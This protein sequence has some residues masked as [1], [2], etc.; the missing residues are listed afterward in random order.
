M[1]DSDYNLKLIDFGQSKSLKN[2]SA[3][4]KLDDQT[5]DIQGLA[6]F[7][8]A[9]YIMIKEQGTL[10]RKIKYEHDWQFFLNC[11]PRFENILKEKLRHKSYIKNTQTFWADLPQI[12]DPEFKDLICKIFYGKN[13]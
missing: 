12:R 8:L 4:E 11:D 3:N 13:V 9:L 7:I 10:K 5:R 1:L 6:S 2:A